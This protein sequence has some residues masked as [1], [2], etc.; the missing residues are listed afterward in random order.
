MNSTGRYASMARTLVSS[1]V[2]LTAGMTISVFTVGRPTNNKGKPYHDI[3]MVTDATN[4][5]HTSVSDRTC[6]GTGGHV[7]G[8]EQSPGALRTLWFV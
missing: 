3:G 6:T 4:S 8:L 7:F 1:C 2:P 5:V